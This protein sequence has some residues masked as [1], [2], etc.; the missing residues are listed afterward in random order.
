M[1]DN[2]Q[3]QNGDSF[4]EDR[5]VVTNRPS[6]TSAIPTSN[7]PSSP[8]SIRHV[9][10][11]TNQ[12]W[13]RMS[14]KMS[15]VEQQNSGLNSEIASENHVDLYHQGEAEETDLD[16][17]SR[18]PTNMSALSELAMKRPACFRSTFHEVVCVF[19]LTMAPVLSSTNN[20]VLYIALPRIGKEFRVADGT[21]SW[22]MSASSLATGA[23]LLLMG[24]LADTIGR[25]RMVLFSYAFYTLMS[26]GAGLCK[27]YIGFTI[28]RALQ[29]IASAAGVTAAVGILGSEYL[30]GKRRNFA[31]AA[32]S[33][34]APLGFVFGLLAGGISTEI[35]NWESSLYFF[36][37]V[38]FVLTIIGFFVIPKSDPRFDRRFLYES[39][40]KIDYVGALLTISGFTLFVFALSQ[41]S[42]TAHGWKTPYILVCLFLGA[43]IIA[44]LCVYEGYVPARPLM[45]MHIWIAPGFALCMATIICGWILFTGVVSYY[46]TLYFQN[47]RHTSPILTTACF[48]PMA[49]GGIMVNVFAGLVLHK[50]SGRILLIVAMASFTISAL[51]WSFVGEHTLYWALPF[52]GLLLVVV[53]ADLAYNVCNMHALSTVDKSLQ[54]TAAGVF[55]T[56]LQLATALGLAISSSVVAAVVPDQLNATPSE[57]LKGYRAGYWFATGVGGLGLIFSFF[58]K[59]GTQGGRTKR[60]T[61]S[62]KD[63]APS[64]V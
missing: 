28:L 47:I 29:G 12:L 42:S 48:L 38:Y 58:L 64:D 35:L 4:H 56:C 15:V 14:I 36:A 53:G 57:L 7:P 9:E 39:L 62:E 16:V 18:V 49:I 59:I 34:G 31:L 23:F 10:S 21:L 33:S 63:P 44:L 41:W 52:P 30:P 8:P 25:R 50:I 61:V 26:L 24:Q 20:G 45:P 3:N 13:S 22:T 51:L 32:F 27:N 55:N 11:E 1:P 60:K 37:M 46:A 6:H 54:S 43:L 19:I 40:Q 17:A 2:E 5:P